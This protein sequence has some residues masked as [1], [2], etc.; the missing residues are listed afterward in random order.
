MNKCLKRVYDRHFWNPGVFSYAMILK[1]RPNSRVIFFIVA[2]IVYAARPLINLHLRLRV[3]VGN[4]RPVQ[5]LR[6][7]QLRKDAPELRAHAAVQQEVDC[8]VGQSQE[9]HHLAEVVVARLVEPAPEEPAEQAQDALRDL[10]DEEQDDDGDEHASGAVGLLLLAP[11]LVERLGQGGVVVR[12]ALDGVA[13]Q[14]HPP[15]LGLKTQFKK[16]RCIFANTSKELKKEMTIS[17]HGRL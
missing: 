8:R 11:R 14:I 16:Q 13:R 1:C 3:P 10:G 5:R 15:P 17:T 9:V 6:L 4:R 2:S 7:E 12:P